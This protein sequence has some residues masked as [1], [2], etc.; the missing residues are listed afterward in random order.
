MIVNDSITDWDDAYSNVSYFQMARATLHIGRAKQL[1]L[2]KNT[3]IQAKQI[4]L[5][6]PK[7][8]INWT[9][10]GPQLSQ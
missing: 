6:D 10:S 4:S 3:V 2:E 1:P 5:T 8:V 7:S 9:Y